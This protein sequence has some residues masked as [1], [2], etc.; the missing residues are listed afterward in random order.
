[1]S[2]FL[3]MYSASEPDHVMSLKRHPGKYKSEFFVGKEVK[4]K[5]N[6]M[7]K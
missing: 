3:T 5:S 2:L 7:W 6:R 1:M 4:R